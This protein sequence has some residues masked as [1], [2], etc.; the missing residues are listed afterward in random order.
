M[1]AIIP[2]RGGSK[3]LPQKNIRILNGKPLIAYTIEQALLSKEIDRV[4]VSTD[5]E[6][7]ACVAKKYGAE[8]PF[9]R[10]DELSTDNSKAIDAYIYTIN[11]IAKEE[12]IEI[13]E[14]VVL[15]PTSPLRLSDDIDNA[16][17]L[18]K[19]KDADSVISYTK[20]NHPISW[21]KKLDA[22]NKFIPIFE[23]TFDNRQN[24]TPT[25]YPNG[26]IYV[27]NYSLLC[28]GKY[29]S[30]NSYAYIMPRERSIDIDYIE[31]FEY[32]E[33]IIMKNKNGKISSV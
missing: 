11:R 13:N 12:S 24:N 18:F 7:I 32:A 28:K 6:E 3:G 10:P 27:F 17:N 19:S 9:F 22:N 31:D 2:A 20:E 8:I 5:N 25:Y 4:I 29:Y 21:H 16:V 33:F 26:S 1:L 23:D 30:E 15:L 14:F